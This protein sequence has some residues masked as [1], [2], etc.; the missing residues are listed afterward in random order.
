MTSRGWTLAFQMGVK[1]DRILDG[2]DGPFEKLNAEVQ[3]AAGKIT[4]AAKAGYLLS[5]EVNDSFIAV[6]RLLQAQENVYWAKE[7]LYGKRENLSARYEF[8][9]RQ[10]GHAGQDPKNRAGG[11]TVF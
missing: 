9:R 11:R 2:F 10:I 8:H 3:P 7:R 6:N 1:F 5:H 4:G